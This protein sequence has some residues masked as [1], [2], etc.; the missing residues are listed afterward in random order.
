MKSINDV[1]ADDTQKYREMILQPIED[2]HLYSQNIFDVSSRGDI[3]IVWIFG[4]VAFFILLLA[5]VNFVNLSTAKSANRAKEV[6]LRKVIGSHKSHLIKQ[7]LTESV[8]FSL[9]SFILGIVLAELFLPYFN[10]LADK[11]MTFPW[12]E[13]WFV[14]A[15]IGL[16]LLVGI[17]AGVYPSFYLSAFKPVDVLKGSVSRGARNSGLQNAMVVFQFTTSVILIIGAVV[18]NRQMDFIL[19]SKIGFEKDHVVLFQ[20][21]NTIDPIFPVIK[22]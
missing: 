22:S 18:V 9:I 15:L 5:C 10:S 20:G 19:H 6:G 3:R 12:T 7:F 1:G 11:T 13:L 16:S 17:L 8:L 2:I 21:T 4:T 14:P